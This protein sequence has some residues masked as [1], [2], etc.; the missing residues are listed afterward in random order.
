MI[1]SQLKTC[2]EEKGI[3][4]NQL[5]DMTGVEFRIIESLTNGSLKLISLATLEKVCNAL[6]CQPSDIF[7]IVTI[8]KEA[9]EKR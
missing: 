9:V 5:A 6:E 2:L 3:S 8:G 7:Q 1:I 4:Q